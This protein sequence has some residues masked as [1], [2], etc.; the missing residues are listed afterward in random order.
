MGGAGL[1]DGAGGEGGG[2]G[3]YKVEDLKIVSTTDPHNI[4]DLFA[5]GIGYE[6]N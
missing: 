5:V 1:G 2:A 6:I 4:L 3:R